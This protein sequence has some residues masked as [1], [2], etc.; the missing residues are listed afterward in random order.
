MK[1]IIVLGD[2]MADRPVKNLGGKTPLQVAKKTNMDYIAQNG[3]CGMLKTIPGDMPPGSDTANLSVMGYDPLRFYS[4]R[5][6][7]EAASMGIDLKPDDVA[8]RMNLVSLFVDKDYDGAMMADYSADEI[9]SKEA[10]ELVQYLSENLRLPRNIELKSGVSYRNLLVMRQ[11]KTGA[12][13]TPPHD[14]SGKYIKKYLPDGENAALIL[15]IMQRSYEL[16][17]DHP[18]NIEREINGLKPANSVWLW[19]EGTRPALIPFEQKTGLKGAVI[20]AVDLIKGIGKCAEMKVI[21]VPGA[22]GTLSTNFSGKADAAIRALQ[23]GY[24][25]VYVHIEAADEC[26]HRNELN[27]KIKAIEL[28]DDRVVGPIMRAMET[29]GEQYAIAVLPDHPTPMDI[30]THT[31]DPVP[32]VIYSSEEE[33]KP[34]A[35]AYDEENAQKTGFYLDEGYLLLEKLIGLK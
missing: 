20:S 31:R 16:L 15:D 35:N 25:F 8:Y 21:E 18:V 7:L 3:C 19:G 34:H 14:I 17:K 5:S 6:P 26:G 13:L 33:L 28:I 32:F 1:Y 12:L 4:G 11:G 29:Q 30:N 23:N 27:G 10:A 2:G 9:T 24:D 22:T